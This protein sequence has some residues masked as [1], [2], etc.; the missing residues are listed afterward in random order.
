MKTKQ[1]GLLA[2]L[3]ICYTSATY[4]Q[5]N[6][7]RIIQN[8]PQGTTLL[9][10]IPYATDTI[11]KHKLDI[12]LPKNKQPNAPVVV[13]LHGGAWRTG[14]QCNDMSY[15]TQTI[16]QILNK[17]M[18]LASVD[19]RHS[20]QQV[21]PQIVQDCNMGL[22]YLYQ[23]AQKYG[24]NKNKIALMGFSAGGHL[25]SLT[26][27][28]ANN[29]P[30]SFVAPGTKRSFKITA[31]VD[32]YGPTD[33]TTHLKPGEET[34]PA[35]PISQLIG[36]LPFQNFAKTRAAS[37]ITYVDKA[38]PPFLII[39]G[40]KDESVSYLQSQLLGAYLSTAGV[41]NEVLV[42]KDAPHYGPAFDTEAVRNK[43]I[44]FLEKHL[45][46]SK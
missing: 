37:P 10:N 24:F 29:G 32:F 12:Y 44:T 2:T 15:M 18:V 6:S 43:V 20:T 23:N 27:L 14:D 4:S 36:G 34:D 45:G 3:L 38:D 11:K 35:A 41:P 13:W 8:L 21:W 46:N 7:N 22:E 16:S 17:G 30:A 26:A 42:V 39:N 31:V 1:I 19:Y 33:L 40:E 25:A 5:N 28:A 9:A